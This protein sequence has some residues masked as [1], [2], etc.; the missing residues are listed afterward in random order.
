[1]YAEI[2]TTDRSLI[3]KH[4]DLLDTADPIQITIEKRGDLYRLVASQLAEE[5]KIEEVTT[6]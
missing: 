4:L 5:P 1:M 2:K 6:S 3:A